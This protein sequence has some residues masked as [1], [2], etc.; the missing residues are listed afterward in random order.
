[1]HEKRFTGE[2]A[3]LRSHERIE[4]LEVERVIKYCLEGESFR[5]ILDV[6]TGSG[7]F[8]EEFSRYNQDVTGVDANFDMLPAARNYVPR[9]NFLQATAEA[10]PFISDSFDLVF[11][12][13]VFHEVDDPL[14]ALTAARRVSRKRICL[15]EWTYRLQSFGPPMD[16]R[17]S[18]ERLDE[19]FQQAG[20]VHWECINLRNTDLYCLA[21]HDAG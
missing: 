12:G 13:V 8:A 14:R 1:M 15:L 21:I 16:D 11:Y 19:L 4:R 7:L 17:L 2:I 3:R 20:V 10:L 5:S 9:A 6:G 18:P